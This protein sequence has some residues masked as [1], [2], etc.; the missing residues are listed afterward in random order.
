LEPVEKLS[1]PLLIRLKKLLDSFEPQGLSPWKVKW[2]P[3]E[4]KGKEG[5]E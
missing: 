1:T 4:W 2:N 3:P 5:A